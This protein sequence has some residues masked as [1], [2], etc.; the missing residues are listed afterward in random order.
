L[1]GAHPSEADPEFVGLCLVDNAITQRER[2]ELAPH[3][4]IGLLA[5][6]VNE[7]AVNQ[8]TNAICH[9]V[10][11]LVGFGLV[12]IGQ[13]IKPVLSGLCLRQSRQT[14]LMGK[15]GLRHYCATGAG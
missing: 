12:D 8:T 7:N 2:D 5:D 4:G 10:L 3:N 6:D 11:L 15:M 13:T 1:V 14:H 9:M